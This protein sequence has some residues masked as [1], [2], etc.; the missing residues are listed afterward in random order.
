MADDLKNRGARSL[1]SPCTRSI[2]SRSTTGR[3][4]VMAEF[5]RLGNQRAV[6]AIS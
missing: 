3:K 2:R 6:T 4:H 1:V 5:V